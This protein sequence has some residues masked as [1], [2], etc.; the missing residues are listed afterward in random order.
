M[1]SVILSSLM[2]MMH[3]CDFHVSVSL[4][5]LLMGDHIFMGGYLLCSCFSRKGLANLPNEHFI[6]LLNLF[7]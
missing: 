7:K 3:V 5:L 6:V 1:R 4:Y 2:M